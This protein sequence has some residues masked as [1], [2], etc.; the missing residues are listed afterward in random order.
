MEDCLAIISYGLP[1]ATPAFRDAGVRLHA[2]TTFQ[3]VLDVASQRGLL[4]ESE[5][6]SVQDWLAEPHGWAKRNG[7]GAE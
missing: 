7:F 5:R 1:E 4:D 6:A 2:L 3:A